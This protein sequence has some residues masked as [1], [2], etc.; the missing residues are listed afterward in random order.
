MK[1]LRLRKRTTSKVEL[2]NLM[3]TTYCLYSGIKVGK[4][5]IDVLSYFA[6]YGFKRSTKELI[7]SSEILKTSGSLEN[8]LSKLRRVG[9]IERDKEGLNVMA[10]N[11]NV[12]PGNL[13][14]IIKLE[15]VW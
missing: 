7:L 12:S 9:L 11:L 10:A 6:V 4:T 13:G 2:A 3:I 15:N 5:D 1:V 14:I 8:T